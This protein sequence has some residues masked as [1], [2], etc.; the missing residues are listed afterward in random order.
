MTS[1]AAIEP[2]NPFST[3]PDPDMLYMT[4][5][6]D[7]T[8]DKVHFTLDKRQGVSVVYGDVGHGKS[9]FLRYVYNQYLERNDCVVAYIPSPKYKSEFAFL[10]AMCTELGLPTKRSFLEQE[11][12]LREF[13]Y[14]NYSQGKNCVVLIDEAQSLPGHALELVRTLLNFETD[15][16]KLINLILCGQFELRT[17]LADKTKRALRS[18]I[19][20][21][22]TLNPFTIADLEAMIMFRCDRAKQDVNFPPESIDA[23]F[24]L[25][26]GK[27]RS[28]LKLCELAWFLSL[29]H[30]LDHVPLEAVEAAASH[31]I[32]DTDSEAA[33]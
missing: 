10:K 22:S 13:L 27:P 25:T 3:S 32:L 16:A 23:I 26:G 6:L 9:T 5:S 12:V 30:K 29:R 2:V 8:L 21:I 11:S 19:L 4:S 20:T 14:E 33:S 31:T 18:R 24:R 17:R 28:V 7:E 1:S 15:K